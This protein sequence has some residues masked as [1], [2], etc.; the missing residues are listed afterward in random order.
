MMESS[1]LKAKVETGTRENIRFFEQ[2][3]PST[4]G[5]TVED[6][7]DD[8]EKII[9]ELSNKI[10]RMEIYQAKTN[11]FTRK[12]F[13]RNPNPQIKQRTVKNEDQKIQGPFKNKNFIGGG[14]MENFEELEEDM[15]DLSDDD[16][17]P[18]LKRQYYERYLIAEYRSNNKD[19]ISI[20]K[21]CAYQGITDN[22]MTKLQQKYNLMPRNKN[23]TTAQPKRILSSGEADEAAP[24]A[25]ERQTAKTK[26]VDSQ[27]IETK[28][29]EIPIA[30]TRSVEIPTAK[31]QNVKEKIVETQTAEIKTAEMKATHTNKS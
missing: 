17:E 10:S 5:R 13:R 11:Q 26:A 18:H 6:K 7:M 15:N 29:A 24:K 20:T 2:T 23:T 12:D 25:T 1:K 9:R 30:N 19:G 22:I 21:D 28:E 3:R 4:Y 14:D 27:S 31:T 16:Q 8:M